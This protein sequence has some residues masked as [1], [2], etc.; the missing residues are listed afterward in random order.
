MQPFTKFHQIA[1]TTRRRQRGYNLIEITLYVVIAAILAGIS[2]KAYS[3]S[4]KASQIGQASRDLQTVASRVISIFPASSDFSA[5]GSTVSYTNC[6]LAVNN[7]AFANTVF[8]T[9]GTGSSAVAQHPFG[10]YIT[11]GAFSFN[12]SNDGFV[13]GFTTINDKDCPQIVKA[14]Q[15]SV[16]YMM[17]DSTV[18]QSN[19]TALNPATVGTACQGGNTNNHTLQF[20]FTRV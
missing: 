18:A 15:G 4:N 3:D 5:M 2:F 13:L 17:I 12:G 1:T 9:S 6:A 14:V 11:C 20:V 8:P 7:Q 19:T 10:G 16:R